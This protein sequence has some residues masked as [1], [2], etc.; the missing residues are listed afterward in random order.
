METFLSNTQTPPER[1]APHQLRVLGISGS[2]RKESYNRK[3]LQIAKRFAEELGAIV[4]EIEL[5]ELQLPVYDEDLAAQGF[6]EPV[7]RMKAKVETADVILIASPEYNYSIPGG[8]KNAIDW[9]SRGKNSFGGKTAAIFGASNGSF[10]T[11]RM[12]PHLRAILTALNVMTVPQPQV[13]IRSAG[14]AFNADGSLKDQKL[15]DQLKLL[16]QKTFALAGALK[17]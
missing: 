2:L 1:S 13:F 17:K 7:Q 4:E 12:Q 8:L 9:L 6:P 10:G 11:V 3:A 16:I 5:K 15:H 14:E